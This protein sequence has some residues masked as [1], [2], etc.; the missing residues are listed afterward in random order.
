MPKFERW[1][2][3]WQDEMAKLWGSLVTLETHSCL[4]MCVYTQMYSFIH[5]YIH[6]YIHTYVHTHTHTHTCTYVHTSMYVAPAHR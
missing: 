3:A 5:P 4:C 1:L 2:E 6:T